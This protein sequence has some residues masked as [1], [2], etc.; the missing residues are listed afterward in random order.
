MPQFI[1]MRQNSDRWWD[2]E[3]FTS[4]SDGVTSLA[5]DAGA[6]AVVGDADAGLLALGTGAVLNN[7]VMVRSTNELFLIANNRPIYAETRLQYAEANVNNA[8][9]A[10]GLGDA[11]GA[12]WLVDGGAGPRTTGMQVMI[13]KVA[14]ASVWRAQ[15]RNGTQVSDQASGTTAGGTTFTTLTVEVKDMSTTQAT[16]TYQVDG[17]PLRDALT[18]LMINHQLNLAG[19]TEMRV[20]VYAKAGSA[21]A[22][23][24]N[25]DYMGASQVRF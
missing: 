24:V 21:S 22:E 25:V 4:G 13:Y 18:G 6:T 19:S 5:A 16:V 14:G 15:A 2:F 8:N 7:E 1:L 11:I 10:F 23:T 9:V 20:G 17:V 3:N 12:D